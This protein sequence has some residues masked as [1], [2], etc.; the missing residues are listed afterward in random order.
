M[1]YRRMDYQTKKK[2]LIVE[3]DLIQS[4]VLE[5]LIT[6]LGYDVVNRVTT[7]EEAYKYVLNEHLD[8]ITM[9]VSL[10]GEMDG[11]STIEKIQT[12]MAIPVIYIT[13]NSDRY[14]I[15]RAK[16]TDYIDF[17][18]KPVSLEKVAHSFDLAFEKQ[19]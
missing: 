1:K 12:H 16:K 11:I 7:G 8:L 14:N 13:G 9:D 6:H 2:V 10:A 19:L 15:E 5:K 17:M 18:E 4:L 3:D